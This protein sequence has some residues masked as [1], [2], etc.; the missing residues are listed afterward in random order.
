MGV[1]NGQL[2]RGVM[3][4]PYFWVF[5]PT[6]QTEKFDSELLYVKKWVPDLNTKEYP[7]PMVDH[8][9]ARERALK[10]YKEGLG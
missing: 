2:V 6:L 8:A 9:F 10:V 4:A 5:N 7:K 3:L 1:G